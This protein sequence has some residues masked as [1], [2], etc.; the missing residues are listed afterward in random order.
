MRNLTLGVLNGGDGLRLEVKHAV[1]SLVDE[2]GS[3]GFPGKKAFP[4]PLV[5]L[6]AVMPGL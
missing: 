4:H 2:F 6:S 1:F 5:K 3:E